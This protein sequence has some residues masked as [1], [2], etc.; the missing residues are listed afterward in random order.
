MRPRSGGSRLAPLLS[1]LLVILLAVLATLQYRWIGEIGRAERDRMRAGL[2][3][4]ASRFAMDLD[5]EL[6]RIFLSFQMPGPLPDTE[7]EALLSRRLERW[8]EGAPQPS[9][10][11]SL[12]R[13]RGNDDGDPELACFDSES[14]RLSP[15]S[16]PPELLPLRDRLADWPQR[17]PL[18]GREPD[19][20][21]FPLAEEVPA[22]VIPNRREP[23]FPRADPRGPRS[24]VDFVIV[25]I[26][27]GYLVKDLLPEL[28]ERHFGD[29][30]GLAYDL[31][32]VT[33]EEPRR[34]VFR[35][36]AE[37]PSQPLAN[38]DI[39]LGLF[40]VRPF[41]EL[42][43]L[44]FGAW[45]GG[46]EPR[47]GRP[48][49]PRGS[50]QQRGGPPGPGALAERRP[51]R[52]L[53]S[54]GV[55]HRAGSLEMAVGAARRRNLG[56]SLGIL[57]LLGSTLVLLAISAR[58]AQALARRQ[59]AFVANVSH[60]LHT[61]LAAIRSAGQNLADGVIDDPPKVRRYGALIERE[62]RRLSAMVENVL[63]YA[64]MQSEHKTYRL[65]KVAVA[66]VI[67]QALANSSW[68]IEEN[69]FEVEREVS[70]GLPPVEADPEALRRV[71]QNL[72]EN[73]VKYGQRSH[74]LAVRAAPSGASDTGQV[75]ISVVDRGPGI[76]KEDLPYLFEPFYRGRTASAGGGTAGSGLGLSLARRIVEAH[77]GS[78]GVE[79]GRAD[80]GARFTIRLPVMTG[81]NSGEE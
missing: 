59:I 14:G 6:T 35:S 53:W 2:R 64:G 66:D 70:P 26:D 18:M 49:G 3:L 28:V 37:L 13:V 19:R 50:R 78:L 44:G 60:E 29:G 76:A 10:V 77:G 1:T 12:F 20:W 43:G 9:L 55:R 62:G 8:L 34:V 32:I 58:R 80:E 5:R 56:I 11:K 31:V 51:T 21:P 16:W 30:E 4:A 41:E 52:G 75:A 27:R 36:D 45:R 72:I 73:A 24:G 23:G 63:E 25:G 17:A 69:D 61:P 57:A 33:R 7:L 46:G 74:W 40:A 81:R 15:C 65:Q 47:L 42:R 38:P 67:D 54:L 22:V 48:F 68:L 71:L 79:P 39:E